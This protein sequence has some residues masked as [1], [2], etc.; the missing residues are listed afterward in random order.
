MSTP[1]KT[2]RVTQRESTDARHAR[3][4]RKTLRQ[5]LQLAQRKLDRLEREHRAAM[6]MPA[7]PRRQAKLRVI[8]I[9][10]DELAETVKTLQRHR[11]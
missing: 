8:A 2:L 5:S 10:Q 1:D 6:A 7:G 11:R 3:N 4:R 9:Q